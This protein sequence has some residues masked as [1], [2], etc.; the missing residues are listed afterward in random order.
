MI[1]PHSISTVW[2]LLDTI[3]SFQIT[4]KETGLLYEP[5]TSSLTD[6]DRVIKLVA[7]E[8]AHMWFGNLVTMKWWTDLWLNEGRISTSVDI[9]WS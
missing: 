1:R 3:F 6:W 5:G 2:I 4:Y 7:H 9:S 8:L